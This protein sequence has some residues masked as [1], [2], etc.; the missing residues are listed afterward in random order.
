MNFVYCAEFSALR[1][2]ILAKRRVQ[3]GIVVEGGFPGKTHARQK[4][5]DGIDDFT[6]S[7]KATI[8]HQFD[9]FCKK[10]IREEARSY[11]RAVQRN[12]ERNAPLSIL[13]EE[14]GEQGY[15][16]DQ[17]PSDTHHFD[18]QGYD[19]AIEN[20]EL[21]SALSE[22]PGGYRNVVLLTFFMEMKEW[23][24]GKLMHLVRSTVSYRLNTALKKLR[25]RME[26]GRNGNRES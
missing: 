14:E 6:P 7:Q 22:L 1:R 3:S 26:E 9:S 24:I 19:I 25:R 10:I 21:A 17:Y 4:G 20:D 16:T 23:E 5:V 13:S 2:R 11:F 12:M 18:A 15:G 8:R